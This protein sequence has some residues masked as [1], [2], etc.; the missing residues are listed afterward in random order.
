MALKQ[1]EHVLLRMKTGSQ[2]WRH[3]VI[4]SDAVE[5]VSHWVLQP[6][7]KVS[8]VDF[9]DKQIARI[10]PWDGKTLPSGVTEDET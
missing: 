6:S 2:L 1:R 10:K 9:S 3:A 8:L 4:L 7:R 5:E